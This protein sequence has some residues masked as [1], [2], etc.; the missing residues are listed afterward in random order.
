M[1]KEMSVK[2][3]LA[4]EDALFR[5]KREYERT[6]GNIYLS[7]SG[8]KDSTVLAHLIMMAKL[9]KQIPFVFANTGIELDATL[10]FVKN[11]PYGNVVIVKPRKPFGIVL[12]DYGKPALSKLKAEALGTYGRHKDEPLKTA[13]SRQLIL[14]ERERGGIVVGGR[15]SYKLANKDMHFI[16]PETEFKVANMCCQYMK[17]YPFIDFEKENK[18]N[19]SFTGVRVAEG[20]ARSMA[21]NSCVKIKRKKESEF[22]MS[23]PIIDWTDELVDEFISYY[24]IKLS[25]AYE[26]YGCKRTG[27]S[28]CPYSKNL[29]SDLKVLYDYEPKKY[30][31]MMSWL[32]DVYIYQGVKCEW[33]ADYME[34]FNKMQP[35][36]EK[37]RSEMIRQFRE[38]LLNVG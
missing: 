13:R 17:K 22:F 27:C 23:M 30:K 6:G 26:V 16:H 15:N 9:P 18:M 37:R 33:D 5:I 35:I 25:D 29:T 21:Y 14:G 36:I 10:E 8:G 2:L 12:R 32:K 3:Q 31:A 34:E 28:A 24:N 7:F 4:V 20:G 1:Q 11:F 19:G 38:D